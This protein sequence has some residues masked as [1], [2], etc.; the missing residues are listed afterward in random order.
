LTRYQ[1]EADLR[2]LAVH[3]LAGILTGAAV[4]RLLGIATRGI[5][6]DD[7]FSILLAGRS[8]GEIITGTA[9]DTMP[10][11]YYFILHFWEKLGTSIAFLRLPGIIFSLGIIYV[12]YRIVEKT[13]NRQ[14]AIWAAAILAV[15]PLQ[16]YHAQDIRM[17]SLATLLILGWDW[18]ALEL[19]RAGSFREVVWWKWVLLVLC[20]AGALYSHALAGFGLL[21]PYAYLLLKKNWKQL[22]VMGAAGVL[23]LGLYLPWLLLVPGQIAKV[24]HAFWTPVPGVVEIFQ[25][26]IMAF[27]DIPAPPL[28][29]GFVLF[30]AICVTIMCGI[31]LVK[32]RKQNGE[33]L[34]FGIMMLVP[35]A[36]LFA[37]SYAMRPM[38]VPRAFLSAYVG[39]AA[40]LGVILSRSRPV[41]RYLVGGLIAACAI[42][43]LPVSITY[44]RFP[45]SPFQAAGQYLEQNIGKGDVVLHD[46]KL[47]YFPSRVY[48]PVLNSRFL[49]DQAGSANDTLAKKSMEALDISADS[50]VQTAVKGYKRVYFVVF[51]Q[52]VDEYAAAGGHPVISSLTKLAGE[53]VKHTFGDLQ[54]L[55]FS[56]AK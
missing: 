30:A 35:P 42:C 47:S 20:G 26:I 55:E 37:L 51:N 18:G 24:Q 1:S 12:T 38:F 33:L 46:N 27:G 13:A 7:A 25:S 32:N 17:Y 10:P 44:N 40:L 43:T 56:L 8:T 50:D 4:I 31:N 39:L 22:S 15:S 54:V 11:L 28:V 41:D 14:A 48:S 53:P 9:A 23:A 21:V 29:L 5:Q 16:Y 36:C 49:A 2:R 3:P 34:F 52:A 19:S 6:Y 45:R